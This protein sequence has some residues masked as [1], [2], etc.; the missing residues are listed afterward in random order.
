M[1]LCMYV[2]M[3]SALLSSS[4]SVSVCYLFKLAVNYGVYK[5]YN[6]YIPVCGCLYVYGGAS[7][8]VCVCVCVCVGGCLLRVRIVSLDKI[9]HCINTLIITI[10]IINVC[11]CV[12]GMK[13]HFC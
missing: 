6:Q 4:A 11:V 5:Y 3:C 13:M 2:F 10:I 7:V 8:C 12:C 9:L 1:Y